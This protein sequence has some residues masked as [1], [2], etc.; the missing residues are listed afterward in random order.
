M[1]FCFSSIINKGWLDSTGSLFWPDLVVNSPTN[2]RQWFVSGVPSAPNEASRLAFPLHAWRYRIRPHP[3][4][5]SPRPCLVLGFALVLGGV[6]MVIVN[7]RWT[8]DRSLCA[9]ALR[10]VGG[11]RWGSVFAPPAP[12]FVDLHPLPPPSPPRCRLS[13]SS[14][15]F[16]SSHLRTCMFSIPFPRPGKVF[17]PS[18]KGTRMVFEAEPCFAFWGLAHFYLERYL[19]VCC[20]NLP[21][22]RF[23]IKLLTKRP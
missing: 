9:C 15:S 8:A 5:R 23:C 14:S 1:F 3:R 22:K 18:V 10:G 6:V 7:C 13:S 11:P 20:T 16:L 19:L 4:A 12:I 2:S 21:S 17:A